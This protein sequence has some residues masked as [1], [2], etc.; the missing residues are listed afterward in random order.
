MKTIVVLG[1]TGQQGGAVAGALI[2]DGRWRVRA[3]SRNP[4]SDAARQLAA[5]G[6]EVVAGNMDDPASLRAA[7]NG[8]HGVFS[9][10]GTDHGGEVEFKRGIAVADAA[11]A[12]GVEHFIYSSVGGADR[13]SGVPHFESKWRIEEHIRN[14]GLASTIVRPVFFMDN[15]TKPAMRAILMALMRSYVPKGKA[16][17]MIATVDIGRWVA[18][19]FANRDEFLNRAEE[20]AGD[21]RTRMEIIAAFKRQGW[22]AGLALPVP[23]LFLRPLPYDVRKMFDWFGA[24]GYKADIP[25]LRTRRP[26]IM[27]LE[28]WLSQ[29]DAG[30]IAS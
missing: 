24:S 5:R 4:N 19:A 25:N 23:K 27:T 10:Q 21:Q 8:A 1:A 2:S 26:G 11:L 29:R 28:D 13:R 3:L 22:S 15:F 17:Q 18:H 30:P 7:L 16:L 6:F 20:I 12:A 9:V 14:I